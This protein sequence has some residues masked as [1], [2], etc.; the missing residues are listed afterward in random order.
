MSVSMVLFHSFAPGAQNLL[1]P[2]GYWHMATCLRSIVV[3]ESDQ[4]PKVLEGHDVLKNEAAYEF[5]LQV[6]CGL[7]SPMI[8]ET[9]ILGQFKNF[10]K[11]NQGHFTQNI[12]DLMESLSKEAKKIRSEFLQNLGCTSYG[13]LLRKHVRGK[14]GP[15]AILGAG[16]L[17]QDIL[18]WF[19]K[20][21]MDIHVFTRYPV[22]YQ[23]L[24]DLYKKLTLK[25]LDTLAK[26]E[27]RGTLVIAAPLSAQWIQENVDLDSFVKIYDLRGENE[28]DPIL[29][30]ASPQKIVT[31]Q[32]LFSDIQMNQKQA[33]VTKSKALV[34]IKNS[35]VKM[36]L[37]ERQRPFGWE[38]L[39]AYS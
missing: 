11:K 18:P 29:C 27:T 20:M 3:S 7:H 12:S 31:M 36:S 22:K 5:L 38:D 26:S 33:E 17:T 32:S 10:A 8:G 1:L 37:A 15:I 16:S 2:E 35:T 28:T 4:A 19:G 39:W 23:H 14:N 6:I 21:D 30:P 34:E 9:E 13:S 25:S 24:T